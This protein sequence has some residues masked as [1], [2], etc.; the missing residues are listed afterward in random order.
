MDMKF[1]LYPPRVTQNHPIMTDK[2]HHAGHR[3]RLRQRYQDGGESAL[4][5]YELLELLL[6]TAIP[7]KDVKPIAKDLIATFETLH[8][9]FEAPISAL[10]D[11]K[12]VS[13]NI[14]IFLKTMHSLHTRA[15]HADLIDKP[16]LNNWDRLIAYLHA[17]MAEDDIE[18]FRVLYLN[19]KNILIEDDIHASGTIDGASVYTREIMKKAMNVGATALVLVH[20][21]PSGDPTPSAMDIDLTNQIISAAKPLSIDIHDHIIISRSGHTSLKSMGLIA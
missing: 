4:A 19:R 18:R 21:H 11:V 14:A 16:V 20:N 1:S 9:M 5:D 17:A 13:G 6:F 8:K 3:D 10:C 15:M 2:P 12:G 7:R